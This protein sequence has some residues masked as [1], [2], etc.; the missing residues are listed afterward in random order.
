MGRTTRRIHKWLGI[1][2]G[3]VFLTWLLSGIVMELPYG[4]R[5]AWAGPYEATDWGAVEITPA[6]AVQAVA[7]GAGTVAEGVELRRLG[8]SFVYRVTVDGESRL[9][10]ATSGRPVIIDEET[11]RRLARMEFATDA[12]MGDVRLMEER[13]PS[14]AFGPMPAW[15]IAWD[16]GRGSVSYV[17][18]VDGSV[19]RSDHVTRTR[20]AI[21]SLHSFTVL[22]A[23][24]VGS[25]RLPLLLAVSVVSLFTVVTGYLLTILLSAWYRRRRGPGGGS[26]SNEP[27]GAG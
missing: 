17:A 24:G 11:A 20:A 21:E 8:T 3:V 2:T 14:Y 12:A 7:G 13:E 22:E 4:V 10:D 6:Q 9:V 1:G 5:G 27:E 26:R 16:D 19:R 18:L 23:F 15:R 25:G